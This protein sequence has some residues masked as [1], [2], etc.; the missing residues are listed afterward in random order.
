MNDRQ[1]EAKRADY[2]LDGPSVLLALLA[3]GGTGLV[4]AAILHLTSFH[5]FGIPL[6]LI[7]LVFAANC[8]IIASGMIWTSKVGKLRTRERLLQ[9]IPW[10]GDEVVL[11]VGCGRGLMLIGAAHHLTTGKAVGVDIWQ[12]RDLSGNSPDSTI[13]NAR[14]EGVADRV[15]VRD[16]DARR[17]PYANEMFDVVLSK[18]ALHNIPSSAGRHDSIREIVRVLKPGGRAVIGDIQHTGDYARWFSQAGMTDVRRV[19]SGP[20]SYLVTALTWGGV[21][22]Y[23]VTAKKADARAPDTSLE[24]PALGKKQPELSD[25]PTLI[26]ASHRKPC[27]GVSPE[28]MASPNEAVTLA[29]VVESAAPALAGVPAPPGYEIVGELGRGG[30]GVVYEARD[31]RLN[32]SVALKMVLAGAHA[33]PQELARFRREAEAAAS[34]QH[35]NIVQIYEV[36]EANGCPYLS[37]EFVE[38]GSLAARLDGTPRPAGPSA[39]II[40]ALARAVD[41]AHRHGVI[42]RDLKPSNILLQRKSE[43]RNPKLGSEPVSDFEFRISDFAPKICDFG[44]AKRIEDADGP[45]Q[46]GAILGTP[47]YMAP[48]QAAGKGREMGPAT[49]V[50]A[51]GAVLYELVTGRPPFKAT[52]PVDTILQ[53]IGEDPVPPRRLQPRL[54]RDLETIC[55][56]CLQKDPRRRYENAAALA[57]DL[58]RFLAG[59]PVRARP[60]GWAEVVAKWAR[61]RPAAAALL[62]VSVAATAAL[63]I[64][65]FVY[66]ARLWRINA[67]LAA[68][69]DDATQ[70][71]EKADLE[72]D[73]AQAHLGKAL[74]VVDHMLTHTWD[75]PL[76]NS[77]P[78][79]VLR[80]RLL[81]EARAYY[82]W[83]LQREVQ[84]P[85][86]RRETARACF[87]TAGLHLWLGE[88]ADAEKF[89]NEAIALQTKL[90]SDFPDEP[91]YRHDISKTYVYLGHAFAMSQRLDR[92]AVAY[93][94][95]VE[96]T[97]ALVREHP[98]VPEYRESLARNETDL[99]YFHTFMAP[100][101][102]EEKF[103]KVIKLAEQL[104]R[105]RPD[106][107][108]YQCLLA[109]GYANLATVKVRLNRIAESEEPVRKGLALLQPRGKDAPRSGRDYARGLATLKFY[110]GVVLFRAKRWKESEACLKE[111]IAGFEQL[112]QSAPIFPY[113]MVLALSYP[114]LGQLYD[115]TNRPKL[116]EDNHRKA[117]DAIDQLIRDYPAVGGL[118]RDTASDDRVLLMV[119]RARRGEGIPKLMSDAE[120]LARQSNLSNMSCYNLACAYAQAAG[121]A[122]GEPFV[123]E[124]RAQRAL[125]LLRR[126]EK[127]NFLTD[128]F[129]INLAED[130]ADLNPL[131]HRKDFQEL[132]KRLADRGKK[133]TTTGALPPK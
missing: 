130:D 85:L 74:E 100:N 59:E 43:I 47:S 15:E 90:I 96:L 28:R 79:L 13:E 20:S 6:R 19:P 101:L 80:R 29:S 54:P 84:D 116:A 93:K 46:S 34:L 9:S 48:E 63:L 55:L 70:A 33:G 78:V 92:A 111:G 23:I 120:A 21:R 109:N 53:V 10:R 68:A 129:G 98:D 2:G 42:H 77:P 112:T 38:G 41:V 71:K 133:P 50:Y 76:G 94:K 115:Q 73:R 62:G 17:L 82:D 22:P 114:V 39:R 30:M 12:R 113:R 16:G 58:S 121:H 56:K 44:L 87:R 11:D 37:L 117:S 106:N 108:D 127:A 52:T 49:D 128:Q 61:R 3:L 32:R 45:T 91:D 27:D 8:L 110:E 69:L 126:V 88:L 122:R 1:Y 64:G 123:A 124:Y 119:Y 57:D 72:H 86:V 102:A 104:L 81:Q 66:Q 67:E 24:H 97:E 4:A 132:R 89:G 118:L 125:E 65:G 51:L 26:G 131:R 99:G 60:V 95:A 105:E 83:S 5:P 107:A 36:G 14:I 31:V 18:W 7:A 40:E 103:R 25:R 35:P 75:E